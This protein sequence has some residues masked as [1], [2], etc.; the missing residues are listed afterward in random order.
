MRLKLLKW[1][2]EGGWTFIEAILSIVIMSIMVLGMTIVLMAFREHLDRSWAIRVMDQY[3]NDVLERLTH[4][5]RNA[6]DV[7]VRNS[8]G[9]THEIIIEYPDPVYLDRTYFHRWKADLRNTRILVDNRPLYDMFPPRALGRGEFYEILEFTL[10]PYGDPRKQHGEI[11]E[12]RDGQSRKK[13]FLNATYDFTFTL[14]Y[15]RN[16][17]NP[18]EHDWKFRKTYTNRVYIRNK[19]L[20]VRR[21]TAG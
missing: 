19:N 4:E 14:Q 17:V 12:I 6:V 5:L 13:A 3:G 10:W 15:K 11:D 16:A 8:V 9:E 21:Q 2:R 7:Q 20:Y 18:G 1:S